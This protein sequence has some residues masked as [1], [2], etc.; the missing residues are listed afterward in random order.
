[1]GVGMAQRQ[2]NPHKY[3]RQNFLSAAAVGWAKACDRAPNGI[4]KQRSSRFSG[5]ALGRLPVGGVRLAAFS[6]FKQK[7]AGVEQRWRR[8]AL[9]AQSAT[10][11]ERVGRDRRVTGPILFHTRQRRFLQRTR[12]GEL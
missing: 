9:S 2:L 8:A 4:R 12:L 3:R 6:S 1:M 10:L 5:R 7:A 11:L